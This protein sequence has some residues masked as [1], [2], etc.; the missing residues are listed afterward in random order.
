MIASVLALAAMADPPR[1]EVLAGW[2]GNT[3]QGYGYLFAM[4]SLARNEDASLVLRGGASWLAYHYFEGGDRVAVDSPGASLGLGFRYSPST[5]SV[6]MSAGVEGRT[7]TRQTSKADVERSYELGGAVSG[8][9]Y[10]RPGRRV[11]LFAICNFSGPQAYVWTRAGAIRQVIPT[12]KRGAPVS[13]WLGLDGTARGNQDTRA[14]EA[15]GVA[16]IQLR[17]LDSA[18]SIRGGMSV[19]EAGDRWVREGTVGLGLYWAY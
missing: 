9:V 7:T 11:A 3:N 10:W 16:E 19:E 6:G 15:G 17:D 13:L 4:P 14:I 8:D 12:S 2:A 18:I 5:V 1:G